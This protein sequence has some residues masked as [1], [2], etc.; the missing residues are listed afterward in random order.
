MRITFPSGMKWITQSNPN[1][2]PNNYQDINN[3]TPQN[4]GIFAKHKK[5]VNIKICIFT[6][7]Y[8]ILHFLTLFEPI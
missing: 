5:P 6:A 2:Q 4:E 1:G 7:V 8:I 3:L